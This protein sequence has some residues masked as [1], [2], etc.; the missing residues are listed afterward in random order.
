M[1]MT[2]LIEV[3]A[4]GL[5][6]TDAFVSQVSVSVG[7]T[8]EQFAVLAGIELGKAA[9]EVT[10]PEA[11]RVAQVL[12]AV[13]DSVQEGDLLLVLERIASEAPTTRVPTPSTE[14]KPPALQAAAP[15]SAIQDFHASPWIRGLAR[16]RGLDLTRIVGTGPRGRILEEDLAQP[17]GPATALTT[18]RPAEVR[19]LSLLQRA[20]GRTVTQTWT[21]VPHVTQFDETDITELEAFR[22]A[23]N[24]EQDKN[25]IKFTLLPFVVKAV[26]SAL[27]A[28]PEFNASLV[29]DDLVL[30]QSIHIG[31][32]VD[33]ADGLRVPVVQH[34]DRLGLRQIAQEIAGLAEKARA[35]KLVAADVQGGSF[36]ISN[37]GGVGGTAFTPIINAPE[38][39]I[40]G[41]SKATLKPVWN[42][43]AFVPRL[44]LPLSLS[45][46]HRVINGVAGARFVAHLASVLSELRRALL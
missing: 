10:A 26:A 15:N 37:L 27:S 16:E 35:S 21:Q 12:V 32:A 2:Q 5:S 25:A 45:Y 8:V 41:L 34:A 6:G 38:L 28:F 39:S 3:R 7:E 31:F 14:P 13:N 1:T 22:V 36:T 17:R 46:D 9:V 24:R 42:G 29:G 40:L 18:A 33:T 43:S 20:V 4:N 44:M 30:K 11:A 19:P 23:L